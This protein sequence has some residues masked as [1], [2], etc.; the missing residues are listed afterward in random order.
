MTVTAISDR[1]RQPHPY[2]DQLAEP[3]ARNTA[4]GQVRPSPSLTITLDIVLNGDGLPHGVARLLSV[5]HELAL[6]LG[7][8]AVRVETSGAGWPVAAPVPERVSAAAPVPE[9]VAPAPRATRVEDQP[10][11]GVLYVYPDARSV[12]R[13]GAVVRLT[14]LEF[15]LLLCFCEHPGRLFR[16]AELLRRVWGYDQTGARTVD[17]HVRRLRA[18]TGA[19]RPLVTTVHGVGYRLDGRAR[20]SVVRPD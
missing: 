15:D 9:R 16:R 8:E 6:E 12:L 11:D 4:V 10:G 3:A 18:K 1:I 20:V 13:D 14:R 2:G 5:V 19:N 7:G 17:V